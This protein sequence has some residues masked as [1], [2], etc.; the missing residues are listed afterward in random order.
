M[1]CLGFVTFFPLR[2]DLSSPFFMAFI[3]VSTFLP[4]SGEYLRVELFL[5]AVF[6]AAAF[7]AGAFFAAFLVAMSILLHVSDDAGIKAVARMLAHILHRVDRAS[8]GVLFGAFLSVEGRLAFTFPVEST[9]SQASIVL[10][11]QSQ[12]RTEYAVVV[13]LLTFVVGNGSRRSEPYLPARTSQAAVI[14]EGLNMLHYET[15]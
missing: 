12:F 4:V 8:L 11:G 10:T 9:F 13:F 14:G 5:L 2:P 7:F 6:F 3:S 15:R 1:A